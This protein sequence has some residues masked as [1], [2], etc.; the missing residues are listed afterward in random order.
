MNVSL[1]WFRASLYYAWKNSI[2]L[3]K[4]V[5]KKRKQNFNM[6][7]VF[8]VNNEDTTEAVARRCSV[9]KVFFKTQRKTPIL[10]THFNKH[11]LKH[12]CFPVNFAKFIRTFFT[13]HFRTTTSMSF[14]FTVKT[15]KT[16]ALALVCLFSTLI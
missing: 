12:N 10:D 15:L 14:K 16:K 6:L 8:G 1:C 7:N 2:T 9:K 11:N 4:E 5:K 3:T 13:E